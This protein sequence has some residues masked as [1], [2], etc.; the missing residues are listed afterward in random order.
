MKK[1]TSFFLLL[2]LVL[3]ATAQ[4]AQKMADSVRKYRNIPGLVYAV[5]TTD[6]IIDTGCSGM[7]KMGTKNPI[8]WNNRFQIGASTT[9][10]TAY[11]AARMV[12]EGK[13]T[14]NT[15]IIKVFP[16]LDG[17]TMKLYHKITL[18]QWLSMRAGQPP[19]EDF[20]QW[21]D[22]HSLPGNYM[23][24]RAL[25]V[26]M[27]LKRKPT[28]ITD[29]SKAVYSVASA[30]IAAAMLERAAKKPWE[31]LVEQYI[32]SPLRIKAEFGL[33][34]AKDSTQPW[35]HWD[36][37]FALSAHTDDYWARFFPPIAPAG[38][39]N[40]PMGD[41]ISFVRDHLLA[42]QGKKSVISKDA[43]EMLFFGKPGYALGWYNTKWR[44]M[45]VAYCNG[46]GGLYSSYVEVIPEKNIAIIVLCNSGTVDGRSGASNLGKLLRHKYGGL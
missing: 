20:N 28:L 16:E 31:Q 35:G 7:K 6:A 19:Y 22:I 25:F 36:N 44:D 39:I 41:Y 40:L 12:Q 5:F 2:F 37:Y 4:D 43:A 33:P 1:I 23:Q 8:R 45:D 14:W 38:N 30:S 21:R 11:V 32:N 29:S 17:K 13:I 3:S 10:F 27:M 15:P 26:E 24:Q 9:A 42:L 46:R 34:A 18:Q